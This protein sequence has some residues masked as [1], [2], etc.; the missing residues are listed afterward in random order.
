M[1]YITSIASII[2]SYK[3]LTR[4]LIGTSLLAKYGIYKNVNGLFVT[5][6][7]LNDM[8]IPTYKPNLILVK[9]GNLRLNLKM[10]NRISMCKTKEDFY[11]LNKEFLNNI[12]SY[13]TYDIICL[14]LY[15]VLRYFKK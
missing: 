12:S 14:G 15:G 11:V 4:V 2:G 9:M 7:K 1:N 13:V 8:E 10:L 6:E 3:F 5:G